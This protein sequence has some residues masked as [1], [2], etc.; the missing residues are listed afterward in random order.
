MPTAEPV[1]WCQT[2]RRVPRSTKVSTKARIPTR[3]ALCGERGP[4]GLSASKPSSAIV[5][6]AQEETSE[7]SSSRVLWR[8]RRW[9]LS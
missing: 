3:I 2:N 7:G 9:S 5:P 4:T 6:R 8:I 1:R